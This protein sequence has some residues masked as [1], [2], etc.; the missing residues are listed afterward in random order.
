MNNNNDRQTLT[1]NRGN[2]SGKSMDITIDRTNSTF[3]IAHYGDEAFA[4]VE[5]SA[6]DDFRAYTITISGQPTDLTV[7][8]FADD[9]LWMA[10]DYLCGIVREHKD[11]FVA[12]ALLIASVL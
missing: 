3:T 10:S 12:A 1:I 9:D 4:L 8:A 7:G 11:P 5:K 6:V 2:W